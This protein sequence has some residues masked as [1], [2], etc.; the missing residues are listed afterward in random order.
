VKL[1]IIAT[2]HRL[3][4]TIAPK[5]GGGW[6]QRTGGTKFRRC[7]VHFLT[8]LAVKAICEE[9]HEKQDEIAPTICS[10]LAKQHNVP[11][12]CMGMGQPSLEDALTDK[13]IVDAFLSGTIPEILAG[14]Y[15]LDAQAHREEYMCSILQE[16][17]NQFETVLAAVGFMHAGV[18]ARQFEREQ[19]PVVVFQMTHGLVLDES[20]T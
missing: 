19:V 9:T 4:Q 8:S 14:R 13:P 16:K 17:L 10:A 6:A 3:Q 2:D 7:I 5:V 1:F 18:L 12:H 11:W 15:R 20:Q